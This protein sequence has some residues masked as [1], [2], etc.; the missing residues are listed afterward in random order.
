MIA[1]IMLSGLSSH[2]R[3]LSRSKS[4]LETV[5]RSGQDVDILTPQCPQWLWQD[6]NP[7]FSVVTVACVL[8]IVDDVT[9]CLFSDFF[10]FSFFYH[11]FTFP[12]CAFLFFLSQ[13]KIQIHIIS[14]VSAHYLNIM[15]QQVI[16]QKSRL[17]EIETN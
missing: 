14:V 13:Q 8:V 11:F 4:S 9:F 10:N 16:V 3:H 5:Y 17:P 6:S 2:T 12:T 1:L 15:I 7:G